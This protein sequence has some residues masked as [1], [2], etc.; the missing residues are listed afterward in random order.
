MRSSISLR[1]CDAS[2]KMNNLI[3]GALQKL[4]HF[5]MDQIF[6]CNETV[7]MAVRNHDNF[8]MRKPALEF[9]N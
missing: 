2:D 9:G 6:L 3:V 1:G 5:L 7:V 4:T 8:G